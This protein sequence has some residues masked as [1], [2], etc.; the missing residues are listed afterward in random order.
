MTL[1]AYPAYKDSGVEWLGE[2][3]AHWRAGK[4]GMFA[5]LESG[6]TPSRQHPEYWEDCSIPWF[7][8][9]DVWQIR[10]G[11][12]RYVSETKELVSELGLANSSARLLPKGT[13]I[14]SRTA[15]VGFSAIMA[16]DMA[17]TQDFAN[18]VCGEDLIPE[19]LLYGLSGMRP[20]FDRLMMGSTHQ[21]IYMPDIVK[22]TTAVPPLAEQRAVIS[23]LDRETAKI[24]AL[25]AEQERLIGLLA[26]KRRAVVSHAVTKGLDPNA[27]MK[28]SG[29]AWLGE[30]PAHWEVKAIKRVTPALTVG[31]VVEPS[32]YYCDDGVPALR[33]L[34]V[35]PGSIDGDNLVFI[36]EEANELLSKS[37]LKEG[38]VVV[39]RTGKPGTAAVISHEYAGCNC[40]DLIIIRK[41]N[42]GFERFI[43]WYFQ[44][45]FAAAQF[46]EGAGGAIQQHFNVGAAAA[47]LVT[48]P[49]EPEQ[50]AIVAHLDRVTADLDALTAEAER[51]VALLK[52]RRAALIS[53]AVTGK[54]DVRGLVEEAA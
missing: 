7:T 44:S 32:K 24:D 5:R 28:D 48:W 15:S 50:R 41:P 43:C 14:L 29:I 37:K 17:T 6:H 40:I 9:A 53:A 22:L 27:P 4:I 52:E 18:W 38:D 13:V 33:S 10:D 20:E 2:V 3:P 19:F 51:A 35:K 16:V 12:V 54:I 30:V 1:P 49:A 34:N 23:F 31:I 11:N 21:T 25:V 26:E 42:D 39:V 36:S 47:L 8:L 45:A 46:S